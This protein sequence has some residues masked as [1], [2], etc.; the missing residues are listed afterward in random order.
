MT[1]ADM[2]VHSKYSHES[3]MEL[4]QITELFLEKGIHYVG[5]ADSVDLEREN[6]E[7]VIERFQIR[8]AKIDQLNE[9]YE[10]KITLLKS[11]EIGE[12]YLYQEEMKRLDELGF[13]YTVGVLRPFSGGDK[14][15][16][17]TGERTTKEYYQKVIKM[18]EAGNVDVIRHLDLIDAYF[19]KDYSALKQISE[20]MHALNDSHQSLEISPF[21]RKKTIEFYPSIQKLCFYRLKCEDARVIIGSDTHRPEELPKNL[22]DIEYACTEIGLVPGIYQKRKFERI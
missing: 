1:K 20:V 17:T 4:E 16:L 7:D 12:P 10:G 13:D 3:N 15:K 5:I 18:I 14:V 11:A 22:D 21:I 8:N 2:H 19:G 9:K 6:I